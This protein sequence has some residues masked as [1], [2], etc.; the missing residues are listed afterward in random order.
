MQLSLRPVSLFL[1]TLLLPPRL[2]GQD[3][4]SITGS[5]TDAT[6][7]K[8]TTAQVTVANLGKGVVRTTSTNTTGEYLVSGLPPAHYDVAIT[9]PRFTAFNANNVFLGLAQMVRLDVRL[10]VCSASVQINDT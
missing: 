8:I 1:L 3:T 2:L 7:A 9:V 4:A 6:G 10:Q 5:V